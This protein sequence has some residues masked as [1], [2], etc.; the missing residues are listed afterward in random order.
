MNLVP[1]EGAIS[2]VHIARILQEAGSRRCA[3]AKGTC[4]RIVVGL[5]PVVAGLVPSLSE[6]PFDRRHG[7][8]LI[9]LAASI[10]RLARLQGAPRVVAKLLDRGAAVTGKYGVNGLVGRC[11]H[12]LDVTL[13]LH[14]IDIP[15]AFGV[16]ARALVLKRKA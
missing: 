9:W 10:L 5:Q 6:P 7:W 1:Q 16:R 14:P 11:S 12:H 4:S 13:P 15:I 3:Y 2:D 8:H